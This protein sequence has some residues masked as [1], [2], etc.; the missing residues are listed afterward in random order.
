MGA[1]T[2]FLAFSSVQFRIARKNNL[3]QQQNLKPNN[4]LSSPAGWDNDKKIGILHE[5][6]QTLKADDSFED[7]ITK[8]PVRKV[9]WDIFWCSISYLFI[10]MLLFDCFSFFETL[11]LAYHKLKLIISFQFIFFSCHCYIVQDYKCTCFAFNAYLVLRS[12]S[13]I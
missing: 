5:N 9:S 13:V 4:P 7:I 8:P 10:Y 1:L 3:K 6:F 11:L 2:T 12:L